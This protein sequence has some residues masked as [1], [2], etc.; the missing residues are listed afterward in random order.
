MDIPAYYLTRPTPVP[1]S[2][3][4][5]S[6]ERLYAEIV[7]AP[8]ITP[9]DFRFDAPKWQFLCWLCDHKDVLMHG[10][11][12]PD[13][14]EFEPRQSNDV[15]EF[16]NR[17]AVYAASDGLWATYFAIVDREKHIRSLINASFRVRDSGG[18][19]TGPYYFFSVNADALP[20]HPWRSGTVYILPRAG[21]EQQPVQHV[22]GFDVVADHWASASPVIPLAKMT[23]TPGDFPLLAQVRG[24][25]PEV[26][27]ARAKAN[28]NGFPWVVDEE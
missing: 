24:H 21:F 5:E 26:T 6:F 10:S 27:F 1:G 11:G 23:V 4:A 8:A 22:N 3:T 15:G 18:E 2:A 28:P 25:D 13:I 9:I 12:D 7:A 20:H 14:A 17:R 16:G 19:A